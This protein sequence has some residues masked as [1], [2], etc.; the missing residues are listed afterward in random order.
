GFVG[1][2]AALAIAGIAIEGEQPRRFLI[3]AAGPALRAFGVEDAL[4][5]P[6]LQLT[7]A[8]GQTL[9]LNDDWGAAATAP[10]LAA[11]ATRLGAF[12]LAAGSADAALLVTL[13]PGNYTTLVSGKGE[14]SGTA[15]IEVYEVP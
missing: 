2:G 5:D 9:F 7:S 14:S 11:T 8:T 13:L 12:A 6:V 1:T 10:E 15:L 4:A 3:R